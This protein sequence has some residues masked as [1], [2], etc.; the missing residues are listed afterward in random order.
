MHNGSK[1]A[2]W[3]GCGK[4][5]PPIFVVNQL[6]DFFCLTTNE[7]AKFITEVVVVFFGKIILAMF[8]A[9]Q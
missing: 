7:C 9:C 6:A 3:G 1:G 5:F 8:V 4:G 2:K